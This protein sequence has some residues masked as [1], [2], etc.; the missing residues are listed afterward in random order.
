[1]V[2]KKAYELGIDA[3]IVQD[4]GTSTIFNEVISRFT[5]TRKYSD[6]NT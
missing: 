4:V 6:D 1:M 2:A 5:Y 3:L